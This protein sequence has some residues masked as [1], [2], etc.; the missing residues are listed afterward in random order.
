MFE[1]ERA[2]PEEVGIPSLSIRKTL[3]FLDQKEV[4]MH[5]LLIMRRDKLIFEK[6]YKPYEKDTLHRMFSIS[7]T[8]TALA[9]S[10]LIDE[11][12]IHYEDKIVSFFPEYVSED[13]HPWIKEMTI[14]NLLE[15]RTCHASTTYKVD[16][17]SNWVESF[18]TVKPTHKPGTVFH[19]DTSA[20]HTL[21]A[22][23][24]R[25]PAEAPLFSF[26]GGTAR[27]G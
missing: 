20:A 2:L 13:T 27:S 6:Y 16:M 25:L 14:R 4:P 3:E 9:I 26:F 19:Y 24:P 21:S 23:F 11:G 15:M 7:K 5:S 17:K 8:F 1:F 18:F 10:L 12:K 22:P